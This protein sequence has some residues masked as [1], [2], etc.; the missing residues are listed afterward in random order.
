MVNRSDVRESL[1]DKEQSLLVKRD[2]VVLFRV[3]NIF[4]GL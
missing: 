4:V 2:L 1:V 3:L